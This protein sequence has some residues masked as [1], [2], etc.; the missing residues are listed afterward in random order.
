[1]LTV[2]VLAAPLA[3]YL[4]RSIKPGKSKLRQV[5]GEDRDLV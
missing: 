1:M 3:G 4:A 2:A 5:E